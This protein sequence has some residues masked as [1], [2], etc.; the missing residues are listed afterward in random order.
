VEPTTSPPAPLPAQSPETDPFDLLYYARLFWRRKWVVVGT[1]LA[2][3]VAVGAYTARQPKIYAAAANVIIDVTAPRVLDSTVPEVMDNSSS[4][5]WYNREY[6][7]TQNRVIVSRSVSTRVAEKLGLQSD[8]S[9]LGLSRISDA[10]RRAETMK[11]MD[12]IGM[13]QSRI[14][15][16]PVKDSRLVQ[17]IVEDGDPERAALLANEVADAYM[18]E[19]LALKLRVTESASRWLEDR[20]VDLELKNKTSELAVYDFKKE[21]DMLTTSLEDRA[22]MVSQRLNTYNGALTQVRTRIAELKARVD[23]ID[24]AH[25]QAKDDTLQWAVGLSMAKSSLI[26]TLRMNLVSQRNECSQLGSRYLPDHPK[27]AECSQKLQSV[28]RELSRELENQ[29][30]VARTD[31]EQAQGEEKNLLALFEAAKA[32]GFDVNR[33]QIEFD[34][35]KRESDNDR[36]LYDVVLKRMKD[37]ELSGL[38]RTSNVRVLDAARPA[39]VPVR[40]DL[41]KALT[42]AMLVGLLMGLGVALLLEL[43]DNSV[44]SQVDVEQRVGVPF[45]GLVPMI[46]DPKEAGTRDLYVHHHPKSSIAECCRAIRTNVLFMSPERPLKTILVTSTAPQEGKST[47]VINLGISMAQ[48]GNRVVLVD[49]DMRRPRL[50]KAFQIPND[51]GVSTIVVGEGAL[52]AAVKSTDVPGLFVV[53]CGPIPPNPAE[54]L[55]TQA[56]AKLLEDLGKRFDRIILDSP[57][58]HPVADAIVLATQAEGVV[59]ILKAGLTNRTL[60]KRAV[61]ALR[62]VKAKVYGAILNSVDLEDPKYGG[63]YAD[64]RRYGG[65]YG[66]ER[67]DGAVS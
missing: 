11:K 66:T 37:I 60:A 27:L 58:I 14:R 7:E 41:S 50:H 1:L 5:Y 19:N 4:S 48:S 64:Y 3:V 2:V 13:L 33:K 59:L 40:P 32:E 20:L 56:F 54:L 53:P 34:R 38:L 31:L 62:D 26:E 63:Y 30:R 15:V 51:V 17:I 49:T 22:S 36:R 42:L 55:H 57:P 61:R 10:D 44:F 39:Y 25:Q 12:A 6:Y 47:S 67:R 24:R 8:P 16:A 52:D 9:F 45:L 43:M 65:Y 21:K 28:E 18:A 23:T 46:P 35:L 29:V